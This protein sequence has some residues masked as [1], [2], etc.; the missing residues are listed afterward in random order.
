MENVE[1][2]FDPAR[3]DFAGTSEL[4]KATYWGSGRSDKAHERAFANSLCAGAYLAGKQVGFARIVTDYAFFAHLCDVIVW[5]EYRGAG[6]ARKL[7]RAILDH[8]DLAAVTSWTLRTSD[9]HGLYARFGFEP[10]TD[11]VHMRLARQPLSVAN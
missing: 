1:I 11:G 4:L 7:V 3:I 9:A 10:S 5:P 2:D 6:I 8:P